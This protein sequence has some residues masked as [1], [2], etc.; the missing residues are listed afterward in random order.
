MIPTGLFGFRLLMYVFEPLASA[1][2]RDGRFGNR[3]I[4][5]Q[6]AGPKFNA[7][8]NFLKAEVTLICEI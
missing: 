1:G 5:N 8:I 4:F 7:L 2:K 3:K 6:L